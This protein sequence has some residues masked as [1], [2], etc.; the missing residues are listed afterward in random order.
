MKRHYLFLMNSGD[1]G[2][3]E[4]QVMDFFKYFDYQKYRISWAIKRDSFSPFLERSGLAVDVL[5]LPL[6]NGKDGALRRFFNFYRFFNSIRPDIIVFSQFWLKSFSLPELFA[7][8]IATKGNIY[9]IVHD[10]ALPYQKYT[11]RIHLGFLPGLGLEWR[12]ER[13][14]QKLL[15][16]LNKRVIVVSKTAREFLIRFHKY[17]QKKIF[18]AYHGVDINKFVPPLQDKISLRKILNIPTSGKLIISTARFDRVKR[19]DRLIES[20]KRIVSNKEE[21]YLILIGTGTEYERINAYLGT[22]DYNIGSKIKALGF[23]DDV[24][25]FL[26]A[27]DIYVLPSDSEG[28]PLAF[29]EAMS[30][31][32]ICVVTDCG[33]PSEVI[34]DGYNAFLVE[35]S[36]DGV[37]MGL[38]RALNLSEEEMKNMSLRARELIV[39]NFNLD[40]KVKSI[41]N[42]LDVNNP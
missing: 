37:E 27:S 20:F 38:R 30:C 22:L 14:F 33:G 24:L 3:A 21:I 7:G 26:Q 41:L 5:K 31:G 8:Y 11:S 40:N 10:S 32:L 17:P 9:M 16:Y 36:I 6:M 1:I 15:V 29:L 2:G 19:I 39:E 23:K 35:K 4:R 18:L 13:M 28:M 34:K 25:E 42:L 12:R